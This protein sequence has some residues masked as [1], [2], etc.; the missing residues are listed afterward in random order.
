MSCTCTVTINK[1][2]LITEEHLHV[3][4]SR[5]FKKGTTLVHLAYQYDLNAV[6]CFA[7]M[8]QAFLNA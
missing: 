1:M 2:L 6:G 8:R 5:H 7:F 3:E 4:L